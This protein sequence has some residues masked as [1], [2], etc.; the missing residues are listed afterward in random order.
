M[1]ALLSFQKSSLY[2]QRVSPDRL[3]AAIVNFIVIAF[4]P[5]TYRIEVDGGV[6]LQTLG[7][8]AVG[9]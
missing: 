2:E 8:G 9:E 1:Q 4:S 7:N 5:H 6:S 3:L